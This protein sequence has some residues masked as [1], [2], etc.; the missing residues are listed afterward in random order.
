M[1]YEDVHIAAQVVSD[2]AENTM[3]EAENDESVA[4]VL[5]R[6]KKEMK[7]EGNAEKLKDDEEDLAVDFFQYYIRTAIWIQRLLLK[8]SLEINQVLTLEVY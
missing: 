1:R 3:S 8:S 5:K 7:N 6:L 4:E 2:K